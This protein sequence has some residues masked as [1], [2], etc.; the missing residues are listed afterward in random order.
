MDFVDTILNLRKH[1]Y[2][3]YES[4]QH[5]MRNTIN[6]IV[7]NEFHLGHLVEFAKEP[8]TSP[9]FEPKTESQ[10]NIVLPDDELTKCA[11][12]SIVELFQ[13]RK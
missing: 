13:Q 10:D 9:S 12:Q 1:D 7:A 3:Y 4:I 5:K 8:K 2:F 6:A 11:L